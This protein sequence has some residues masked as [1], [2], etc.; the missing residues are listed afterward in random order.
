MQNGGGGQGGIGGHLNTPRTHTSGTRPPVHPPGQIDG[1]CWP[2]THAPP[3]LEPPEDELDE[4]EPDELEPDEE[5]PPEEPEDDPEDPE[6][7][8]PLDDDPPGKTTL[9]PHAAMRRVAAA[10]A[11]RARGVDMLKT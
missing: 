7:E 4:L 1:P 11:S 10:V 8:P 6:L 2:S 3:E 9:P 5:E